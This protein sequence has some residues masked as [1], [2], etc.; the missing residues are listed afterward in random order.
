MG[1]TN[2]DVCVRGGGYETMENDY[3]GVLT[4]IVELEYTKWPIRKLVLFKCEWF[5]PTPNQGTK[6]DKIFG[7]IEVR[8]S[9]KYKN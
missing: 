1:T 5:D 9:R 2:F 7:I 8:E 6:I 4:N 3:Y